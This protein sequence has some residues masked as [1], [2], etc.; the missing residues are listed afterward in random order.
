MSVW[1]GGKTTFVRSQVQKE[2]VLTKVFF[3][4]Y[5]RATEGGVQGLRKL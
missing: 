5:A 4:Q 1:C 3:A 2:H